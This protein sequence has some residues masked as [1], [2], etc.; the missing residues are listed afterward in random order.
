MSS[1]FYFFTLLYVTRLSHWSVAVC[2]SA[3]F[4]RYFHHLVISEVQVLCTG[5]WCV[6]WRVLYNCV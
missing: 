2:L 4:V 5:K 6:T 1:S 3:Q